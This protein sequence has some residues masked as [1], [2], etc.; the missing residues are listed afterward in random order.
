MTYLIALPF[1]TMITLAQMVAL[2]YGS[3]AA[4]ASMIK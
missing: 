1:A 4:V 3:I 2:N